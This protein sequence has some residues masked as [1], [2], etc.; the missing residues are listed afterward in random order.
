MV[1]VLMVCVPVV[2]AAASGAQDLGGWTSQ[3]IGEVTAE[4]SATYNEETMIWAVRGDGS[5]ISG[6]T[7]SFHY[8]Y[9]RLQGDGSIIAKV[10][11]FRRIDPWTKAGV[12]IRES[13]DAGSRF[14]GVY[15]TGGNGVC[16]QAR[17][18]AVAEVTT[19]TSVATKE[20]KA[21]AAPVWIKLERKGNRFHG[22]YATDGA[23]KV[24]TPMVW[25]PQAIT[26]SEIVYVGLAVTSREAGSLCEARFSGVVVRGSEVTD[27]E[28]AADPKQA[29]EKAYQNLQR[30][31]N[32]REDA[33]TLKKYG[34]L[35]AGS[36]FAIAKVGEL[37]GNP[38]DVVLPD[39]Y[40]IAKLLPD[41]PSNVDALAR[42]AILDGEKGLAYVARHLE[43]R[44]MEDRD[45][46]YITLMKDF[47]N[48]PESAEREAAIEL[49]AKHVGKTPNFK[50]LERAVVGLRG[51]EHAISACKSLIQHSMAQP[52]NEQTAIV[53]LRYMALKLGRGQ[54]SDQILELA[55]WAAT[56]FKDT[57]LAACAMGVMAD[58]HYSQK[59]YVEVVEVFHPDLFS[60]NQPE[61]EMVENIENALT[62]YRANTLL[63]S[64]IHSEA[65]CEALGP[66]AGG[67]GLN[68]VALHCYRKVAE[69]RGLSLDDFVRS[70]RNGVKYSE[71]SPENEVWFWKGLIVADEGDL[72]T[73]AAAYERFLQGDGKSVLAARAYYDIG[74]TKMAIGEDARDRIAEAKTLSPCDAVIELERRLNTKVSR[75]D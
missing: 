57:K 11:S 26:M 34:D 47:G 39:Y 30:L 1:N 46:F 12:M 24:W 23:G 17:L 40:R 72:G 55:E 4:G 60:G 62:L 51:G 56:Q 7:D 52:S 5:D 16:L 31:G 48:T 9:R 68:I 45:K 22:Y 15:S 59:R 35:I 74:R 37:R 28:I 3:D 70:A 8:A 38:A 20:Q 73:A 13:L 50:L 27:E 41:S 66:K 18:R 43:T 67:L 61:S 36:L 75:Q 14:A 21:L 54:G 64:E 58:A 2:L 63:Q 65:I 53:A 49:F 10:E 29:L 33:E 19:D 42:I 71:S 44:P 6:T 32:W 69:T 25:K